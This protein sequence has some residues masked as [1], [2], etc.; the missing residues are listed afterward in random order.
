M[1]FRYVKATRAGSLLRRAIQK[2]API[3]A[4][5]GKIMMAVRPRLTPIMTLSS[6]YPAISIQTDVP[7][8]VG[9]DVGNVGIGPVKVNKMY[10]NLVTLIGI[11]VG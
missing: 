9:D 3:I 1:T 10:A 4:E 2:L 8:P 5:T 11:W 7:D 6:K